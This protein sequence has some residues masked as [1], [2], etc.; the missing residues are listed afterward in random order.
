MDEIADK[1]TRY[2]QVCFTL[3]LIVGSRYFGVT[4][5]DILF[6]RLSGKDS[7]IT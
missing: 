7:I 3:S 4:Y 1:S 6:L 5:V 2:R